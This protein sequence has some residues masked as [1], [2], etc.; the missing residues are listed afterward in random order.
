VPALSLSK[1]PALSLSKGCWTGAG[2]AVDKFWLAVSRRMCSMFPHQSMRLTHHLPSVPPR[3]SFPLLALAAALLAGGCADQ[4]N[5][6]FEE[7]VQFNSTPANATVS[8]DGTV[9]GP[10]PTQAVLGK[11]ADTHIVIAKP[12]FVSADL[13]VHG[14]D[15]HLQPN[16]VTVVLRTDLLPDKPGPNPSAEMATCLE[17]LKKYVAIGTVTPEDEP[18]VEQQIRDFYK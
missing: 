18:L 10:T 9:I 7:P 14:V 17:N 1:V 4:P 8:I 13:Y 2:N 6:A 15:G 5:A 3:L 11:Q 12:G 16:P